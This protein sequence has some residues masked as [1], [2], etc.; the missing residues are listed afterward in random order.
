[1][2][3]TGLQNIKLQDGYVKLLHTKGNDGVNDY[4][5]QVGTSNGV[6]IVGTP[7][8]LGNK[9]E[10]SINET[11]MVK[12]KAQSAS[13]T[14]FDITDRLGTANDSSNELPILE[15]ISDGSLTTT[16]LFGGGTV[17][18]SRAVWSGKVMHD[19]TQRGSVEFMVQNN[20]NTATLAN[21]TGTN[22]HTI[23][24]NNPANSADGHNVMFSLP[25][26]STDYWQFD[27][28][29]IKSDNS[30]TADISAVGVPA[31][32][33]DTKATKFLIGTSRT[34]ATYDLD[35]NTPNNINLQASG[36]M[37]IW[38][39]E[40]SQ[41]KM[42][43]NQTTKIYSDAKGATGGAATTYIDSFKATTG[44]ASSDIKIGTIES[45]AD[46]DFNSG[47]NIPLTGADKVSIGHNGSTSPNITE[48]NSK[49]VKLGNGYLQM[50]T[51]AAGAN[52]S[53]DMDNDSAALYSENSALVV[54]AH[55]E[56]GRQLF[57]QE[58]IGSASSTQWTIEKTEVGK[59]KILELRDTG[60]TSTTIPSITTLP[61]GSVQIYVTGG[62][63]IFSY[64]NGGVARRLS[65]DMEDLSGS[66]TTDVAGVTFADDV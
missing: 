14:F 13:A 15:F 9:G 57:Y 20:T 8:F 24:R 63:L 16:D 56:F 66:G 38:T 23:R 48:L 50:A 55:S 61:D 41:V 58:K 2:A 53:A 44:G 11:P 1:M 42:Y 52:P 22:F 36:N 26:A 3:D 18:K 17:N 51:V 59:S 45:I 62:K 40:N 33:G 64:N 65:I 6:N 49:R 31:Q 43:G 46:E 19:F 29:K 35:I 12:I 5:T 21:H 30:A 7:L 47:V 37:E 34:D 28:I 27:R 25:S 60:T 10:A 4:L 32:F 39:D 54:D